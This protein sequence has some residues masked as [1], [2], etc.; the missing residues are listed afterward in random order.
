MK[1]YFRQIAVFILAFLVFTAGLPAPGRAI[2]IPDEKKLAKEFMA[3]VMKQRN[4]LRDPVANHLINTVG[5]Q[6]LTQLPPQPF[7]YNFYLVNDDSFN[8]FASPAAN[9]FIHR[10]LITALSST[11]ELA[12][13]MGHEI[14]HAA[15]R[16]VSQSID[17]SKLVS[18]GSMAGMLAG[19]LIGTAGG[20]EAGQALTVG[21]IAAGQSSMLAFTRENETEA[22][23]KALLFLKQ[24]CYSPQGLLDGLNKMRASDYQGIEGIPDYFKTHPG[25]G[26][27]IAHVAGLLADYTPPEQPKTCPETYDYDMVKYRLMGLYEK[28]DPSIRKIEKALEADDNNPALYYG[29]GILYARKHRRDEAISLLQKALDFDLFNPLIL[30]ELGRVYTIDGQFQ[31]AVPVL[32]GIKSEQVI[33]PMAT[34]FLAVAQLESG[35]LPRA[36]E[37]LINVTRDF[38]TSFPRAYYYLANV[39]SREQQTARSHYYLGVYYSEIRDMKNAVHHL[40]KALE[41]GLSDPELEKAARER[42]ENTRSG[43]RKKRS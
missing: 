15:S 29:L 34:Y 10:G 2:S 12:G 13:I 1:P 28:E 6:I 33:G 18:I 25:T 20:G 41:E 22:D 23:Q 17:R 3:M 36:K 43:S 40:N 27:R 7:E 42:L 31:K 35:D 26:K 37:N 30:L 16:H 24:T 14:A 38:P 19:I 4:I 5:R 9:I 8:A 32:S 39:Y 11:D 21:S